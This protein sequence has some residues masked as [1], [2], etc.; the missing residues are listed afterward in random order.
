MYKSI[1]VKIMFLSLCVFAVGCG[2]KSEIKTDCVEDNSYI[3]EDLLE[4]SAESGDVYVEMLEDN[5]VYNASGQTLMVSDLNGQNA[6]ELFNLENGQFICAIGHAGNQS[7]LVMTKK[8]GERDSQYEFIEV[9]LTGEQKEKSKIGEVSFFPKSAIKDNKDRWIVLSWEGSVFVYDDGNKAGRKIEREGLVESICMDVDGHVLIGENVDDV[10]Q[11]VKLKED[12]ENEDEKIVLNNNGMKAEIFVGQ[13]GKQYFFEDNYLY[14]FDLNQKITQPIVRWVDEGLD[15]SVIKKISVSKQGCIYAA[16]ENDRQC[17]VNKLTPVKKL[18][19]NRKELILACVGL[20][21]VLREQ[22]LK[23]NNESNDYKISIRDYGEEEDPYQALN[24]DIIIGKQ[25]DIMCMEGLYAQNYIEKG[26]LEDLSKYINVNDY[27][28]AYIEAVKNDDGIYQ[29][30][31]YFS[32][33]TILGKTSGVGEES[34]WTD[35]EMIAFLEDN[36]DTRGLLY[37]DESDLLGVFTWS[38]MEG[39]LQEDEYGKHFQGEAFQEVLEFVK[40]YQDYA[41]KSESNTDIPSTD[42]LYQGQLLLLKTGISSGEDYRA[43]KSMFRSDITAKGYPMAN[44][45]G[46]YMYLGMPVAICSKSDQKEAAWEFISYLLTDEIQYNLKGYGFPVKRKIL[47]QL[48]DE[49]C[50]NGETKEEELTITIRGKEKKVPYMNEKDVN[51]LEAI[52]E[53]SAKLC[54]D[55]PELIKIVREE[56]GLYFQGQQSLENTGKYLEKR[57]NTYLEE[58][59]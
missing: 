32:V 55:S 30:S 44:E 18:S 24:M 31:P 45:S 33:Q 57:I 50:G 12:L 26:L 11:I 28:H 53:S 51:D 13:D 17:V 49:W 42:M 38:G 48:Y 43:Y 40:N 3:V 41:L 56:S 7:L 59:N 58:R 22:I 39:Y 5:I 25:F 20:N 46:N 6:K 27:V 16:I 47:E 15:P 10:Y 2:K 14:Y 54:A 1:I 34:G 37:Y 29:I 21:S 36:T 4:F 52:I 35:E 23:F 19:E 9:N 8:E